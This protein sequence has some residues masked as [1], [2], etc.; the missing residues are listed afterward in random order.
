MLAWINELTDLPEWYRLIFDPDF[1]FKWKSAKV[2][3]GGDVSR[4]MADWVSFDGSTGWRILMV[5]VRGRS[6]VLYPRI[7]R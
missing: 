2:M 3:T 7:H 1:I 4:A 6:T 5:L